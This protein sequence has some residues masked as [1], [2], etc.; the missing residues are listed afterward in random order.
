MI[1]RPIRQQDAAKNPKE[2]AFL[3]AYRALRPRARSL[4]LDIMQDW[5]RASRRL[6]K[7]R[8]KGHG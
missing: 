6:M 5:V 7:D 2:A 8:T 3:K 1:G 4:A